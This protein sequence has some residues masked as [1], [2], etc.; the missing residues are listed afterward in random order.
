M[1]LLLSDTGVCGLLYG[2]GQRGTRELSF[3]AA[4]FIVSFAMDLISLSEF[5]IC[6]RGRKSSEGKL[7]IALGKLSISTLLE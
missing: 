7:S 1:K 3:A 6:Q 5:R 2:N 4:D